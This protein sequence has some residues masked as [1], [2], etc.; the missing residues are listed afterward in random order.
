M[1]E[2]QERP[3]DPEGAEPTHLPVPGAKIEPRGYALD[4]RFHPDIKLDRKRGQQLAL[5][6]T[7]Y[8]NLEK[9][10]FESHKWTFVEPLPGVAE[11]RFVVVVGPNSLKLDLR[12]PA[13]GQ[14]WVET[15]F[16]HVLAKFA[17]TFRPG[18][19]LQS[20]VTVR[21]TLPIDG[22]ARTFLA[23]RVMR[24]DL[25]RVQPFRR[26]I[27]QLGLKLF[28]PPFAVKKADE[29]PKV[30]DWLV[31]VR[32]ESLMEDPS[33][34]FLEAEAGWMEAEGWDERIIGRLIDHLGTVKDYLETRVMSFLQQPPE[35]D[36]ADENRL[37]E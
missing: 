26:P 14:E 18:F 37:E 20:E 9:N 22:D 30:T 7:D 32:V 23:S 19:V 16:G 13:Q 17:E 8:L 24:M 1:S 35:E 11:S 4:L 6:L 2:D 5:A 12:F 15:R 34:L 33:K 27:H 3:E 28:F 10:E 21:G 29:E 31:M 25:D 36:E